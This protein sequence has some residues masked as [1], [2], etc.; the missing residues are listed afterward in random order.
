MRIE[1]VLIRVLAEL[2]RAEKLHPDWP[3]NPIHAGAV[4]AEEA[5]E[6]IQAALNAAE[7]KASRHLMMT[8]A[9]QTAAMALRFLKNFDDEER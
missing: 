2:E 4:V 5:G 1:T 3:R 9:V 6:L 8:E 7:K